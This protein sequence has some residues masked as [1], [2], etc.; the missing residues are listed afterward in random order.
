METSNGAAM[1]AG[2]SS[3][4]PA[5]PTF[6]EP[7]G[8][9]SGS[10]S[11]PRLLFPPSGT[12]TTNDGVSLHYERFGFQGPVVVLIHGWSG[13][14]HYW[15]LNTRPIARTC[16]VITFDLRHHGDSGKSNYG[17]HIARL[18]ADLRDVLIALDLN[19][20]TVV[21]SSMGAAVIWSYFELFGKNRISKAAFVDQAP[22]QNIAID[23]KAG[24]TGCYDI[25]SLTRLQCRLLADFNGFAKDNA[26]F[27]AG[28]GIDRDALQVLESETLKANPAALAA[29]MADHT[30]LD[31]RPILHQISVPCINII[32]RMSA[33][34][35]WWGIEEVGRLIPDCKNYYFEHENHWLYLQ[36]PTKFSALIAAFAN[37]GIKG[38]DK[39]WDQL[40]PIEQL[41]VEGE[42]K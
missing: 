26:V 7:R 14:R 25:A 2:T 38:A 8:A 15:D 31:W 1:P 10:F 32:G 5:S 19:N 11:H 36:Q 6:A 13:S 42:G 37:D 28:P 3:S 16:Q 23:W 17:F 34:F 4:L 22:L 21:G 12:I 39:T 30:A 20:V 29:L 40:H 9:P 18:A 35:P 27:C 24:S 33:V 41:I